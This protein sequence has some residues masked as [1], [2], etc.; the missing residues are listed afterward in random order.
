MIRINEF[1]CDNL[2]RNLTNYT[3]GTNYQEIEYRDRDKLPYNSQSSIYDELPVEFD[4]I[5]KAADLRMHQGKFRYGNIK[6]QNLVNY[7]TVKECIKRIGKYQTDGNLEHIVDAFNMLRI[8]F[9]KGKISGKQL[10][11][12]D[13]GEHAKEIKI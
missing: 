12:I 9:Y 1:F 4:E 5:L 8:E 3:Q 6:R 10:I 7:D 11:P 13:D 2:W